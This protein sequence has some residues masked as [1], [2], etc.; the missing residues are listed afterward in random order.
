VVS[1]GQTREHALLAFTLGIRQ[2]I[3]AVNKMEATHVCLLNLFSFSRIIDTVARVSLLGWYGDKMAH[4]PPRYD[5][6]IHSLVLF[7]GFSLF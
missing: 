3:V 4:H 6:Q 5:I 7:P 2:L 1:D